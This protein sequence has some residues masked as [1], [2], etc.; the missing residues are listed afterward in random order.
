MYV[1][2]SGVSGPSPYQIRI[3]NEGFASESFEHDSRRDLLGEWVHDRKESRCFELSAL[4][5]KDSYSAQDISLVDLERQCTS[6]NR[7]HAYPMQV[8]PFDHE[9]GS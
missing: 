2:D 6:F 4:G 7:I 9:T 5:L 8:N 1:G 3:R